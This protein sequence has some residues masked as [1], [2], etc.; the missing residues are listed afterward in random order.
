MNRPSG[1]PDLVAV[2]PTVLLSI[3]DHYN[4]AGKDVKRR[5]VGVLLG[6]WSIM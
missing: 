1:L 5:V 4:R 3:V 6:M 2:H